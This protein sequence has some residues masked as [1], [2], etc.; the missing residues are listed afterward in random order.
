[1]EWINRLN[2]AINYIEEHICEQIDME[3]V[4]SIA[5]CSSY[6]FQRMFCYMAD[7]TL[8]EYIRRR[9]MS[10]AAS[11]LIYGEK[12][13]D[14]AMKYGYDSPTAF[15][16]AFKMIHG[17]A[18]SKIVEE[19]VTIKSFPPICFR[20]SIK[21]ECEMNY[22]IVK[23]EAF[24]IVGISMPL[25][26]EMEKNFEKVPQMWRK[27]HEEGMIPKLVGMINTDLTAIL[28]VSICNDLEEWKYYIAVA[29][30]L[31]NV[32]GFEEYVVPAC[33]WAIFTGEG[34]GT[35][36]QDLE[37]RIVRD[38]LPTSG[39]EYANA[40]DVEVYLNDDPQN[41]KYE[42]WIPVVKKEM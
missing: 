11:D 32:N 25:E 30:T 23:K 21:G 19:D 42:V 38:W 40:P 4:G 28:G 14:V 15:N 13:I 35:S 12:V 8:S 22:R 39:Y 17:I 31:E 9:K 36:I 24:K 29:S 41:M 20:I 6:H 33:T 7:T 27:A 5:A 26:K 3:K 37:C 18:P 16:R 10:L 34:V 2:S 1:M